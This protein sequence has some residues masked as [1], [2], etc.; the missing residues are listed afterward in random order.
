[1]V[2][3]WFS[4]L[5]GGQHR[6][7]T[8]AGSGTE[9]TKKKRKTAAGFPGP[10]WVLD[11][12]RNTAQASAQTH[13]VAG[14]CGRGGNSLPLNHPTTQVRLRYPDH[15]SS[16][17][18]P[19]ADAGRGALARVP[20]HARAGGHSRD[21]FGAAPSASKRTTLVCL[22][23]HDRP[24]VRTGRRAQ[25]RAIHDAIA[26]RASL[27]SYTTRDLCFW[28]SGPP[29]TA[30]H[31]PEDKGAGLGRPGIPTDT[32]RMG[33]RWAQMGICRDICPE[34]TTLPFAIGRWGRRC[35]VALCQ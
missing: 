5:D 25:P 28:Q 2:R 4:I 18:R 32:A 15:A 31:V 33:P 6:T 9:T 7:E 17:T 11:G 23:W 29:E 8:E 34:P 24:S 16:G 35:R 3:P 20:S 27:P 12:P 14:L 30:V 22:S 26:C 10:P 19:T 13:A 1:M 21:M